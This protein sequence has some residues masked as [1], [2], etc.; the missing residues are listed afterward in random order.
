MNAFFHPEISE[1]CTLS[2]EESAHAVRTLRLAKGRE[3]HLLDG[4]GSCYAGEILD[5][6]PEK[7]LVKIIEKSAKSQPT[8]KLHLAVAPP[9]NSQRFEWFLEKATEIG[10]AEITPLVCEHSERR[11]INAGRSRKILVAAMKQ[12]M[13]LYLPILHPHV[14][15]TDFISSVTH[16]QGEPEIK[17]FIGHYSDLS[18]KNA[19]HPGQ[20]VIILIG[21][22]G[23]FSMQELMNAKQ[24]GFAEVSLGSLRLRTETAALMACSTIALINS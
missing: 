12:S 22:E 18:L 8:S 13:N 9:K 24:N 6:N 7:C 4:R 23:D 10:I 5:A 11:M 3:I 20:K 16:L 17:K 19:Y 21:P 1:I 2:K 14:K 15:F